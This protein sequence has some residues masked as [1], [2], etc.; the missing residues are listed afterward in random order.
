MT[1]PQI[2]TGTGLH[3]IWPKER[4]DRS[5]MYSLE[6]GEVI[7]D[8]EVTIMD[9]VSG[10]V[11]PDQ[12]PNNLKYSFS[13]SDGDEV[14]LVFQVYDIDS[15]ASSRKIQKV[16]DSNFKQEVNQMIA[17]EMEEDQLIEQINNLVKESGISIKDADIIYSKAV[18]ALFDADEYK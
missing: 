15:G 9:V 14:N 11:M 16:W 8:E 12:I 13:T 2:Y 18:P 7:S 1:W 5:E 10:K 6:N 17:E 4:I 3:L